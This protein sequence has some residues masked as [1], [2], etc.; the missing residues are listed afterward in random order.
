[1]PLDL[2]QITLEALS[3]V[4]YSFMTG[5]HPGKSYEK[6]VVVIQFE[7]AFGFGS[8]GNSDATFMR[9]MG[10][11][12]V[13]AFDP[14]AIIIDLSALSYEWGDEGD[15]M[16]C[17]FDIGGDRKVP[18]ALVVGEKCRKAIGTLCFGE[19]STQDACEQDW[20][21][22]SL[23]QA[24]HFVTK[25]LDDGESPPIH[26]AASSGDFQRVKQL[27][28]SGE[29]PNRVD[30]SDQTPLHRA[31]DPATVKLLIDAGANVKAKDKCSWT[32][33][34]NVKNIECARLFLNAGADPDARSWENLSPLGHVGSVEIAKLLVEAGADVHLRRRRSLLHQCRKAEVAKFFIDAG[35]EV[36]CL[37]Q[38]GQTPLDIA[39][40]QGNALV[41]NVLLAHGGK[42]GPK[43]GEGMHFGNDV[44]EPPVS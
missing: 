24:W 26:E 22:D 40:A 19:D 34:H 5:K 29:D 28:E 30:S 27:L 17:V 4:R 43:K 44:C 20:I 12:G 13:Q 41:V 31:F 14:N 10:E 7:G 11:A 38:F 25:R 37:D 8:G 1:M 21:F 3:D 39:Q 33:L 6:K 16:E 18:T 42:N 36:N 2:K 35:V 9:S 32:P 23:D 15:E